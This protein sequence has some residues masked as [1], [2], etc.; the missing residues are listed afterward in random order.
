MSKGVLKKESLHSYI[1]FLNKQT[2][3]AFI[4]QITSENPIE[5]KQLLKRASLFVQGDYIFQNEW[6]ME[7]TNEVEHLPLANLRWDYNPKGDPEW[8][9][10]L[11]RQAYLIDV[12]MAYQITKDEQAKT[13]VHDL[14]LSF[15]Q[16]CPL[17]EENQATGWRTIDTG[18]RLANWVRVFEILPLSDLFVKENEQQLVYASLETHLTYLEEQLTISR[19]QSNWLVIEICGLVLG[20]IAF[21]DIFVTQGMQTKGL[22]FLKTA[23][24]LQI[25][26]DFLQREQSFMYHHEVLLCLLMMIV[27]LERNKQVVPLWLS[28]T[29]LNMAQASANFID[30]NGQQI[31]YGDS[32]IESM[33][34]LLETAELILKIPLLIEKHVTATT[35]LFTKLLFG[36]S[37]KPNWPRQTKLPT[38]YFK[39]SGLSI[40]RNQANTSF[41][42]FKC[43]PLGGGHGHD[44]LLHFELH[45]QNEPIIVDS[46]RYSYETTR[47]HR[48]VFKEAFAHN[49]ITVG[50]KNFNEHTDAWDAL[51]VA[52]PMNQ[53]FSS[54]ANYHFTEGGHLG[55]FAEQQALVN[56][57]L[58]YL[59]EGIWFIFDEVFTNKTL[60]ITSHFHFAKPQLSKTPKGYLYSGENTG[61]F[62]ETFE[63]EGAFHLETC[64]ISPQYNQK[65]ESQKLKYI[66]TIH[67]NHT[68]TFLVKNHKYQGEIKR[69]PVFSEGLLLPK[70]IVEAFKITQENGS[71]KYV[72]VQHQEPANGRRPYQVEDCYIYGKVVVASFSKDKQLLSRIILD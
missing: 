44:D 34:N 61:V 26:G 30:N 47:H 60:E 52:T 8:T 48:L 71:S 43:G 35:C 1:G 31:A 6:D 4:K 36:A 62:L 12:A 66:R 20:S 70:E 59:E 32:D 11:N 24:E 5:V 49:T 67:G 50:Q 13:Y 72:L 53:K 29:A 46:G 14:M 21:T 25:E 51:K 63:E 22:S 54:Q 56:R 10:M 15:I 7:R 28:Q 27:I 17:N 65:Y 18:L 69:V 40:F 42:F 3:E 2:I 16:C 55:Y 37:Q 64:T 58:L 39:N 23:L 41:T 19:G 9:Y 45:N 57:K 38:Y 33:V 68:Q